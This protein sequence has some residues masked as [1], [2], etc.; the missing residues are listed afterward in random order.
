DLL[1]D[2]VE[3]G[4]RSLLPLWKLWV[5]AGVLLLGVGAVFLRLRRPVC[6][7]CGTR[8]LFTPLPP[9]KSAAILSG[10]GATRRRALRALGAGGATVAAAAG[11]LGVAVFRNRG[12][13]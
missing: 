12:W 6:E 11:G 7:R 2:L 8:G 3:G 13:L 10:E 5:P 4:Q 1:H 9:A